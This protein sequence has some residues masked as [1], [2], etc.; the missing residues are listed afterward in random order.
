MYLE[1]CLLQDVLGIGFVVDDALGEPVVLG[2]VSADERL[3][4]LAVAIE[5]ALDQLG[6]VGVVR[7][8]V[9]RYVIVS[10]DSHR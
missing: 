2:A 9:A 8:G 7:T 1:E 6:I 3:E 4:G 5:R 10:G